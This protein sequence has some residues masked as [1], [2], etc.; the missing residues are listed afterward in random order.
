MTTYNAPPSFFDTPSNNFETEDC[1]FLDVFVPQAVFESRQGIAQ[2]EKPGAPV[3]VWIHGGEG[4]SG[5]KTLPA[6]QPFELLKHGLLL[7]RGFRP[8]ATTILVSANYRLGA[9]GA[10]GDFGR[11]SERQDGNVSASIGMQDQRMAI[12]WVREKIKLFGGDAGR[13]TIIRGAAAADGST[14]GVLGLYHSAAADERVL[15]QHTVLPDGLTIKS[16]LRL[17]N[18]SSLAEA[19]GLPSE[20]LIAANKAFMDMLV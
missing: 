15:R 11:P 1:L 8:D 7:P 5:S 2:A 20:E 6:A 16:F 18:V 3:V 13:V 17:A 14:A 19:R 4:L 9:F 12:R 10:F